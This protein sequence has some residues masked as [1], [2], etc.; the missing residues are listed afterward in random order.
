M[1]RRIDFRTGHLC[2]Q[3]TGSKFEKQPVG[4]QQT[5]QIAAA[6]AD[7]RLENWNRLRAPG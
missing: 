4:N 3:T 1:Q 6:I 5:A 7:Y 2:E